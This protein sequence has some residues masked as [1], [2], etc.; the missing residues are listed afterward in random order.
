MCRFVDGAKSIMTILLSKP[1]RYVESE[2]N[3]LNELYENYCR[4]FWKKPTELSVE[5]MD[6]AKKR[7]FW[8]AMA[9]ANNNRRIAATILRIGPRSIYRMIDKYGVRP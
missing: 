5:T 2:L 8:A 4:Y 9:R 6:G 3:E 7:A 1:N